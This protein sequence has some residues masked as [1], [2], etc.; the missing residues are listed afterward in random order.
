MKMAARF[1]VIFVGIAILAPGFYLA[2]QT[3]AG[4]TGTWSGRATRQ[5]AKSYSVTVILD[6]TGSGFIEYPNMKCGGTLKFVRKYGDTLSY[7]ETITHG[8][9]KCS[10]DGRVDLIPSGNVVAWSWSA[11]DDKAT[12]TLTATQANALNGCPECELNY[13][14]DL[15]ACYA[16]PNLGD[17]Q[18]CE[19]KADEDSRTCGASCRN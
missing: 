2:Q 11:G 5:G 7:K 15:Q 13:D 18:K 1:L 14:K 6:G 12:A 4:L 8:K 17:Q 19:D 3:A 16:L 10:E 9:A